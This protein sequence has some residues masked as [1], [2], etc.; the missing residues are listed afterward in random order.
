[1]QAQ[2]NQKASNK[3]IQQ[4]RAQIAQIQSGV[5]SEGSRPSTRGSVSRA[6]TPVADATRPAAAQAAAE[7]P[8]GPAGT[9]RLVPGAGRG[10]VDGD[11]ERQREHELGGAAAAAVE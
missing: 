7:L 1:M 2:V 9:G 3:A 10:R 6:R 8:P 4:L 11:G 5:Q